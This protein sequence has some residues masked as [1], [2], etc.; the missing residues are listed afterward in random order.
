MKTGSLLATLGLSAMLIGVAPEWTHAQITGDGSGLSAADPSEVTTA[1][2]TLPAGHVA[3]FLIPYMR[4]HAGTADPSA[5]I[6]SLTN[7]AGTT[8]CPTSV[9]WALGFGGTSCTTTLSLAGGGK[10]GDTGEHCS[11]SVPGDVAVCNATCSPGLAFA[12]GKA[13]VGTTS[14]CVNRIAVDA[15]LHHMSVNDGPTTAIGSLKVV[16]LPYGNKGD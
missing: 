13:V 9:A 3:V 15:R 4:S 12:E 11:R 8:A 1:A 2:V 16:R 10:V 6:I 5:T 14:T 7:V